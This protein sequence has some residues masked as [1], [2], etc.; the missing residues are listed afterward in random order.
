M[1]GLNFKKFDSMTYVIHNVNGKVKREGKALSF[2]YFAP[3]SNIVAVPLGSRDIQFIFNETTKDFQTLTIQGQI[4]YV[5]ENPKS[6]AEL[7]DFTITDNT[8]SN[9]TENFEKLNQRLNN[10]A[11]TSTSSF[12][13][14]LSLKDALRSAKTISDQISNG[15]KSSQAIKMLGVEIVSIDVLAVRPTPEM[16]KALE[17]ETREALQKDADHAIYSRRNFAVEQ[18]RRIK[19]SELSTEIAVQ[20]KQKQINEKQWEI[21]MIDA[22][23]ARKLR[24]MKMEADLAVEEQ[25]TKLTEIQ[26]ANDKRIADAKGYMLE[27]TLQPYKELDWKTLMAIQPGNLTAMD[28]I[29]FA[30]RELAE[31]SGKI[32]TLNITPDLLET[33]IKN[34][35]TK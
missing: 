33:V 25:K 11:Q 5:I 1:F 13:Q 35:K 19:E 16:A 17:T 27:K 23:K 18:E 15:L 7:F 34:Q 9:Q 24:E 12:I 22:D 4:T 8:A 26:A 10:E 2:F 3:V 6:L 14:G 20:E 32:G 21:K 31:N 28:N 30:F 29:G